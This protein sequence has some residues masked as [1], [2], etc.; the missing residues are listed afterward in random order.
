MSPEL[1]RQFA[2]VRAAVEHL[3]KRGWRIDG[4]TVSSRQDFPVVSAHPSGPARLPEARAST[5]RRKKR[6]DGQLVTDL[7]TAVGGW[8]VTWKAD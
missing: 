8:R 7:E 3:E 1:E 6:A 2:A 4:V 5:T